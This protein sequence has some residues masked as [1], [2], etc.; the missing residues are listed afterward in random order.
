MPSLRS[1][2]WL[3][4]AL[5][6]AGACARRQEAEPATPAAPAAQPGYGQPP[7]PPGEPPETPSSTGPEP[8]TAS[9]KAKLPAKDE[10]ELTSLAQAEALLEKARAEL[11]LP[12]ADGKPA[13]ASE[14]K[15]DKKGAS[16][17]APAPK[18]S[19]APTGGAAPLAQGTERCV[20]ACKA[21]AS[22]KRAAAAVC[23]LAGDSN[24]RCKRAQ[25]IVQ[26]SEARVAVCKCSENGE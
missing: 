12:G 21:F 1:V 24:A 9:E 6:V 3:P 13:D 5:T 17:P 22:L 8:G 11:G 20:N 23:R 10:E 19:A 16:K 14:A 25:A 26:E 2:V 18:A 4:L 7:A 15:S